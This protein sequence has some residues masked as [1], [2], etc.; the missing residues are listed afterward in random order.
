MEDIGWRDVGNG[1]NQIS[2]DFYVLF[3]RWEWIPLSNVKVW[4]STFVHVFRNELFTKV[5]NCIGL[6]C[7]I[8]VVHYYIRRNSYTK[9]NLKDVCVCVCVCVCGFVFTNWIQVSQG[10]V[11]GEGEIS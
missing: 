4:C 9:V 7:C 1:N 6:V 3:K 2:R 8:Y 5:G 10:K 11:L